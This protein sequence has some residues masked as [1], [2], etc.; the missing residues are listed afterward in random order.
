MSWEKKL[1][2]TVQG[3]FTFPSGK[4]PTKQ[5]PRFAGGHAYT[6]KTTK[7]AED[8]IKAEFIKSHGLEMAKW[9]DEVRVFLKIVRPAAKS[10]LKRVGA[11]DL[12]TPDA[13]NVLKLVCDALNGI[14]YV[15]D[16]QVTDAHVHFSNI[17][18][19]KDEANAYIFLL[20]GYY[21]NTR[22]S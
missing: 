3:C 9:A 12:R 6:P 20:I 16:K 4:I 19:R 1:V 2:K 15:D 11:P 7:A 8:Y 5:R 22:L 17:A 18:D 21:E 14:A 13:D 10:D